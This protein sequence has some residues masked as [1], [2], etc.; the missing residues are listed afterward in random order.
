MGVCKTLLLHKKQI[1][2]LKKKNNSSIIDVKGS[3]QLHIYTVANHIFFPFHT[4]LDV[5]EG[6]FVWKN[7][8]IAAAY[9]AIATASGAVLL[10]AVDSSTS[11]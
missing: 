9:A 6:V 4:K 5:P 11:P 7:L 2:W 8:P 1:V 10:F 3:L